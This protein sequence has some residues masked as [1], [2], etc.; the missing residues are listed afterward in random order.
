[1]LNPRPKASDSARDPGQTSIFQTGISH[2]RTVARHVDVEVTRT[3]I[4]QV[5]REAWTAALCWRSWAH[6]EGG[7]SN[8][9]KKRSGTCFSGL[10]FEHL[11]FV[12]QFFRAA[13]NRS[14]RCSAGR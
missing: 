5:L 6:R 14:R 1:V 11:K 13:T 7:G 8:E 2:A 9:E 4:V 3:A 10:F 12:P